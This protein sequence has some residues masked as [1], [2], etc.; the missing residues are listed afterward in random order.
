IHQDDVVTLLRR[1]LDGLFS[2]RDGVDAIAGLLELAHGQLAVEEIV[3]GEQDADALPHLRRDDRRR[4]VGTRLLRE[5]GPRGRL[6]EWNREPERRAD[7]GRAL[8]VD[9]TAHDLDELPRRG[10][11]KTDALK[12]PRARGLDLR[13][14]FEQQQPV[15]LRNHYDGV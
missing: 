9:D 8:D 14:A 11:A 10:E 12:A 13:E 5:R 15:L 7:A 3:L 6:L 2:I 1:R 4:G